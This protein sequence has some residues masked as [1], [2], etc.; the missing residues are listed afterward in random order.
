MVVLPVIFK[1]PKDDDLRLVCPVRMSF[2]VYFESLI[3]VVPVI[4]PPSN[5]LCSH[6]HGPVIFSSVPLECTI[7]DGP[8]F[9]REPSIVTCLKSR[10]PVF[11]QEPNSV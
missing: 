2:L 6:S 9:F 8:V 5:E 11:E 7:V 1:D 3:F 4:S 10:G